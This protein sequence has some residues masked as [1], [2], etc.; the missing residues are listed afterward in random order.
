MNE[1]KERY[2][3]HCLQQQRKTVITA[4]SGCEGTAD[5]SRAH[6]LAAIDSGAEMLEVDVRQTQDG[7]L[8]LYHDV[9]EDVGSCLTLRELFELIE[10][11]K[12]MAMNLDAKTEGLIEP[13]MALA[14]EFDLGGRII[15]TGECRND[16]TLANALGAE[17]WRNTGNIPEGIATNR[18]DGCPILNVH[19][20]HVTESYENELRSFGAS[21]SAWTVN[22][23]DKL[24]QLL[25][26]GI[27][28]ITTRNP[29]LAL[30]LR[31][32]IQGV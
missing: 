21:F 24:R 13:A 12:H 27:A 28:N 6:I 32:E 5:N 30:K 15:F 23:E 19:F 11:E 1:I 7:L 25:N 31:K 22:D 17:V 9:P 10:P 2:S 3:F 14:R 8:Y 4:H 26:L 16:R 29:V 18:A 20:S